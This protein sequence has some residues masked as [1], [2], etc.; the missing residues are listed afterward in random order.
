MIYTV[1]DSFTYGQEL[2]N[3]QQQAWPKLL[4]DRLDM[5]LINEGRPGAGNEYIVKQT[6]KAVAKHK[7]KLA[8][9]AWT[10]CGRQEHADDWGV[11]DIWP[12]CSS[13]AFDKDPKLQYRKDLIKYITVNNNIEHEYRRWLRQVVLLQSF[14]QNH[15]I[16]Y[17][18]CSVF[19]NQHRF[20]KFYKDNQRYYELIDHTKFVGWP[21]DGMVEWAYGT[22]HGP[23]GHPLEQGHQ[24]IAE[25]LYEACNIAR[26]R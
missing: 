3:P 21:N 16:D 2:P 10:S 13:K 14:L 19:D 9:I 11:Y 20:G 12:G 26:Q 24:R 22:P 1:G 15:Q 7:P 5:P 23:G 8:V 17:I 6:I 25:K 4:A 18:M